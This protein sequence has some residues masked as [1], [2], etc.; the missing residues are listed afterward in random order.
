M[1][2]NDIV[3][4]LAARQST[5]VVE[6]EGAPT[7]DGAPAGEPEPTTMNVTDPMLPP[8][9]HNQTLDKRGAVVLVGTVMALVGLIHKV[10]YGN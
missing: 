4:E 8:F 5:S 2:I 9:L 1:P 7:D 3:S 6:R 10:D